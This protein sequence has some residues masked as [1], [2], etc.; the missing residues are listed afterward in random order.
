MSSVLRSI[1]VACFAVIF[2][3]YFIFQSSSNSATGSQLSGYT[4]GQHSSH[5]SQR[6]S[7]NYTLQSEPSKPSHSIPYEEYRVS[8]PV[9][10][11]D[12][13]TPTTSAVNKESS[14]I[15]LLP[16]DPP[17]IG[18]VS[19]LYGNPSH[20]YVRAIESFERY[21]K[22]WNYKE[23][24]LRREVT[25]GQLSGIWNKCAYLLYALIDELAKPEDERVQ[26][27]FWV[28]ADAVLTNPAIPLDIFLPPSDFDQFDVIAARD[29]S[30]FNMGIF[31]LKV[32]SWSV[33][34]MNKV[35]AYTQYHPDADLFWKEQSVAMDFFKE[36]EM[37]KHVLYQPRMWWNPYRRHEMFEGEAGAVIIH[38]PN[39]GGWREEHMV[40]YLEK[41]EGA[42]KGI[43]SDWEVPLSKTRYPTEIEQFW[44]TLRYA[45][46]TQKFIDDN[47]PDLDNATQTFQI[48]VK[49]FKEIYSVDTDLLHKLSSAAK[50]VHET[51]DMYESQDAKTSEETLKQ[52]T[53]G[54]LEAI[55]SEDRYR[56][57]HKWR[58]EEDAE[59]KES[60]L[61]FGHDRIDEET[62]PE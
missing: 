28:D 31:F 18:I 36:D 52:G 46:E 49:D 26:W 4:F 27:L 51:F 10:P 9:H 6:A 48:A 32:S 15:A 13:S 30:G 11:H 47:V 45:R 1:I 22:R 21:A 20:Y 40:E 3:L 42:E 38:F 50:E 44:A 23:H 19:M 5:D 17:S 25:T 24:V 57:D 39:L 61:E 59:K 2:I 29:E 60:G 33:E 53:K 34:F 14:D 35:L 58:E 8:N 43:E 55:D 56:Y 16:P 12:A 62:S 37:K 7:V 41:V 54:R